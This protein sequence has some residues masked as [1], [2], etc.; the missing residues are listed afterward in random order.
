MCILYKLIIVC[1]CVPNLL[2]CYCDKND[3]LCLFL[4]RSGV[5]PKLV[6]F[7]GVTDKYVVLHIKADL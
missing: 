4:L 2:E 6:E 7:L 3:S 5:V 1:T